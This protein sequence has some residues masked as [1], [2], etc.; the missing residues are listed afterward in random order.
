MLNSSLILFGLIFVIVFSQFLINFNNTFEDGYLNFKKLQEN[1]NVQIL[2]F[3]SFFLYKER[4]TENL[5]ANT[6]SFYTPETI[7]E[8]INLQNNMIQYQNKNFMYFLGKFNSNSELYLKFYQKNIQYFDLNTREFSFSRKSGSFIDIINLYYSNF[9][10]MK[11]I[12][13]FDFKISLNLIESIT[14]NFDVNM[15]TIFI[16]KNYFSVLDKNFH[17]INEFFLYNLS[18]EIGFLSNLVYY[19]NIILFI[20]HILIIF[21]SF[22][23]IY[24]IYKKLSNICKL[25]IDIDVNHQEYL[26]KKFQLL[27]QSTRYLI[28]PKNFIINCKYLKNKYFDS[29]NTS[30]Y[31]TL[32]IKSKENPLIEKTKS[33]FD[34]NKNKR[35]LSFET[36]TD[37]AKKAEDINKDYP[38]NVI[39]KTEKNDFHQK[40]VNHEKKH[41]K[42]IKVQIKNKLFK[43][44]LKPILFLIIIYSIYFTSAMIIFERYFTDIKSLIKITNLIFE[45]KTNFYN[46]FILFD[47]GYISKM[48][49]EYVLDYSNSVLLENNGL[50]LEINQKNKMLYLDKFEIIFEN[51]MNS[52]KQKN[53]IESNNNDF[54]EIIIL[55]NFNKP[56]EIC[57]YSID[58]SDVIFSKLKNSDLIINELIL[59]CLSIL[60]SSFSLDTMRIHAFNELRNKFLGL[61]KKYNFTED[62]L[63]KII[64]ENN[65]H[66][67]ITKSFNSI[68]RPY[69]FKYEETILTPFVKIKLN[70]ILYIFI[71]MFML[72][73]FLDFICLFIINYCII[74]KSKKIIK[75]LI[76]YLDILKI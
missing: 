74:K 6:T 65:E 59:E 57:S 41:F 24:L 73:V 17:N 27:I 11:N 47:F 36:K 62:I 76:V 5:Y 61:I 21:I 23:Y 52:L 58:K 67:L 70:S 53:K 15:A 12:N 31:I 4:K 18:N 35:N 63:E 44:L 60:S 13:S 29:N 8:Y 64:L 26:H 2:N 16:A 75:H 43:L 7:K 22:I 14:Q 51:F 30:T 32:K 10:I 46:G 69:H 40:I 71:G 55:F 42:F 68:I 33:Y 3:I 54:S 50:I 66:I 72:V 34:L 45:E 20:S 39:I 49:L 1:Y 38:L 56:E 48:N 19:Y 37:Y 28:N 25:I 9:L